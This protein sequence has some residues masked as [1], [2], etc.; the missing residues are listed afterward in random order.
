M[1]NDN[2]HIK[3]KNLSTGKEEGFMLASGDTPYMIQ[4]VDNVA[5]RVSD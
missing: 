2:H 5:Q 4:G 1:R 3:I